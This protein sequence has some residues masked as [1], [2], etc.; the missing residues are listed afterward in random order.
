VRLDRVRGFLCGHF[1]VNVLLNTLEFKQF[2]L[3]SVLQ[4][5]L[6]EEVVPPYY[7]AC[8]MVYLHLQRFLEL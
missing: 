6:F 8:A 3:V 2:V 1:P 5:Y 4:L 7:I